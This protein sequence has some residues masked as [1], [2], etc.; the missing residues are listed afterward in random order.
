MVLPVAS[1]E[2]FWLIHKDRFRRAETRVL[3]HI[4]VTINARLPSSE[5]LEQQR[6]GLRQ[7]SWVNALRR[8]AV[9][10]DN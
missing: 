8:Q 1:V 6:R 3:R 9:T 4:L 7:K 5:R 2:I 10:T